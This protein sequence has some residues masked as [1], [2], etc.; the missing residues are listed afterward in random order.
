MAGKEKYE[1]SQDNQPVISVYSGLKPV[2]LVT[3]CYDLSLKLLSDSLTDNILII[4]Q[5]KHTV[6]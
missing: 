1:V 2:I 5:V 4:F 6:H 3:V